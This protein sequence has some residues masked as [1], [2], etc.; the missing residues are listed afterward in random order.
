MLDRPISTL[1]PVPTRELETSGEVAR[2]IFLE[3]LLHN[4]PRA[5]NRDHVETVALV[6]IGRFPWIELQQAE[7]RKPFWMHTCS[8]FKELHR[9]Q[10]SL[11][12]MRGTCDAALYRETTRAELDRREKK[13]DG[14]PRKRVPTREI[15]TA[16]I[17]QLRGLLRAPEII[18]RTACGTAAGEKISEAEMRDALER[19]DPLWDEL[20]P[21]E[22]ARIVQLLVERVDC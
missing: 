7:H 17:D 5:V 19:L 13:E 10:F 20:F 14:E 1:V 18:V 3:E 6:M 8:I 2:L 11:R 15:E 4:G 22:Q 12:D 16:V 9:V 21:A